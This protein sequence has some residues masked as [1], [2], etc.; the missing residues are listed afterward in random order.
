VQEA[1]VEPVFTMTPYKDVVGAGGWALHL[2]SFPD[3]S[4]ANVELTE[5]HRRGF[6][7]EVR[8]VEIPEKGRWWR[9]YVGSFATKGEARDATS[10]LLVKLKTDWAKPTRF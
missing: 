5:L 7:T 8:V 2:F 6:K 4:S 3:S 1:P 10:L 9:V